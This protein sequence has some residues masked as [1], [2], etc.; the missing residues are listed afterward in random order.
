MVAPNDG[1]R[2]FGSGRVP[3]LKWQRWVCASLGPV[4]TRRLHVQRWVATFWVR[5]RPVVVMAM[6]GLRPFG[7]GRN[8]SFAL[9]TTSRHRS[10]PVIVVFSYKKLHYLSKNKFIKFRHRLHPR[11]HTFPSNYHCPGTSVQCEGCIRFPTQN[12]LAP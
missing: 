11:L 2:P 8:P 9:H 6:T 10:R 5:S 7:S 3:S 12:S 4:V 1:S